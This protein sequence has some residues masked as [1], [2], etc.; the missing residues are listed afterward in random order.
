MGVRVAR[1]EGI[2]MICTRCGNQLSSRAR[3]CGRCG[4]LQAGEQEAWGTS[5]TCPM[6]GSVVEEG[7]K[8]CRTC[9]SPSTR[10]P[11]TAGTSSAS[12]SFGSSEVTGSSVTLVE[13]R[14]EPVAAAPPRTPVPAGVERRPRPRSGRWQFAT[15]LLVGIAL[16]AFLSS[17]SQG[18][19]RN[20][21]NSLH[22]ELEASATSQASLSQMISGLR[23]KVQQEKERGPIRSFG[24]HADVAVVRAWVESRGWT[25]RIRY[26]ASSEAAGTILSQSPQPGTPMHAGETVT[27][28]VAR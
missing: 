25:L 3:F 11:A 20:Q 14:P 24:G 6:C 28:T 18:G 27:V 16:G 1:D 19:L 13:D 12:R 15:V 7:W 26:R 9:G 4:R 10:E 22:R 8:F 2:R 23:A 5:E 17:L 21:V